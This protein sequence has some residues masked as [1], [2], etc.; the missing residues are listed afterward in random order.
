MLLW[1]KRNCIFF[2]LSRSF[3]LP[4]V[5]LD[6]RENPEHAFRLRFIP[7]SFLLNTKGGVSAPPFVF[8]DF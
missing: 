5:L 3:V 8:N 2:I 6:E 4:I 7:Q 1:S